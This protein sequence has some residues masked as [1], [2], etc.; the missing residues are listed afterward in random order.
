VR[1]FPFTVN[2]AKCNVFIRRTSGKVQEDSFLVIRILDDLVCWGFGLVDEI[3]IEDI[4]LC[5][6]MRTL[7]SLLIGSAHLVSLHN[8]RRWVVCVVVCLIILIPFV[9]GVDAIEVA[10]LAGTILIAP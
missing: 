6:G 3:R 1:I 7:W 5:D 8:F 9:S 4:K 10:R 2:D